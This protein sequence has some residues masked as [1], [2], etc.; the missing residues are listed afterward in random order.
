MKQSVKKRVEE[1]LLPIMP[2]DAPGDLNQA[3][4]ELGAVIC[5][6]NGAPKC[7]ECPLASQCRARASGTTEKFPV[8]SKGK[9]RRIEDRTVLVIRDG[10]RVAIRRRPSRGLLAGLYEFPNYKGH[11]SRQEVLNLL[12]EEHLSPVRILPLQESKHIFSHVEWHMTGYLVRVA[13]LDSGEGTGFLFVDIGTAE[14]KYPVPAAF[15][16]YAKELQLR[17]G[18]EKYYYQNQEEHR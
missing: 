11:L 3:L 9:S 12:E 13:S 6:P 16:A 18:Q 4:M 5:V 15:G 8:K 1:E 7:E 14:E 10:E 17:L 2:K